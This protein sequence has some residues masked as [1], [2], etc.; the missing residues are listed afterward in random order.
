M[1]VILGDWGGGIYKKKYNHKITSESLY[2]SKKN[3]K[4]RLKSRRFFDPLVRFTGA[5]E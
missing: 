1:T 2:V 3:E 4:L 5:V